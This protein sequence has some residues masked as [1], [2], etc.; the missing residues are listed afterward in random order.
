MSTLVYVPFVA[1]AAPST[2]LTWVIVAKSTVVLAG[3]TVSPELPL[4]ACN[5]TETKPTRYA[6]KLSGDAVLVIV[7]T[8]VPLQPG[9]ASKAAPKGA[10]RT[11]LQARRA[12]A[13]TAAR[14]AY[15]R[16]I[17]LLRGLLFSHSRR[18]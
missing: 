13:K 15:I 10:A 11:A 7:T 1:D 12:G 8:A 14:D 16:W 18:S 5:C 3:S 9:S 2:S 6:R 17:D 4:D